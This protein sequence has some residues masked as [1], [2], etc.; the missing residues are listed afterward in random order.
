MRNHYLEIYVSVDLIFRI[1]VMVSRA[2]R[3][4]PHSDLWYT[5]VRQKNVETTDK[6]VDL[7][8]AAVCGEARLDFLDAGIVWELK[9]PA[10]EIC[11]SL[12]AAA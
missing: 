2:A 3:G 5:F 1:Y 12:A 9:G 6:I 8:Q 10:D 11:E 4:R 7:A